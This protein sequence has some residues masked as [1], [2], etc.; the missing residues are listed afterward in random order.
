M[1]RWLACSLELLPLPRSLIALPIDVSSQHIRSNEPRRLLATLAEYRHWQR[2]VR[3]SPARFFLLSSFVGVATPLQNAGMVSDT[4]RRQIGLI[5][6]SR[7]MRIN[8]P[9]EGLRVNL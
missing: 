5:E 6:H 1:V 3:S 2:L 9:E 8:L 4:A 7:Y